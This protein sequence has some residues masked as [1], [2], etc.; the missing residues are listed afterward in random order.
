MSNG[1]GY[2]NQH[3]VLMMRFLAS[4]PGHALNHGCFLHRT[5]KPTG[6]VFSRRALLDFAVELQVIF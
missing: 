6:T 1:H 2:W 5:P 4:G 3:L